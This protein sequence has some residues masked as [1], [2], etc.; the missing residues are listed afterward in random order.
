MSEEKISKN[1][2]RPRTCHKFT[3]GLTD[4]LQSIDRF[5]APITMNV[6]GMTQVPSWPS[7]IA[8]IILYLT[9]T[10]YGYEKF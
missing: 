3:I 6:N 2:K 4:K 8:T 10:A 9:L 5:S 1:S 7:T